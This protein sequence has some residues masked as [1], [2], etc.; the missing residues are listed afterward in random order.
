L[1]R[2]SVVLDA[3]ENRPDNAVLDGYSIAKPLG[4]GREVFF[5]PRLSG[6]I[7]GIE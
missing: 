5:D 1:H 2:Q 3:F 4:I 6:L 7:E